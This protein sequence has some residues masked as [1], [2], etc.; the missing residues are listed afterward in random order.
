MTGATAP[1]PV[2]RGTARCWT[3][4]RQQACQ[5]V[6]EK[7][8][9]RIFAEEARALLTGAPFAHRAEGPIEAVL[10]DLSS[11][12]PLLAADIRQLATR[13]AELMHVQDIRL[14]LEA[15]TTNAC[16]KIHSDYTDLRLI[17]TYSGSGPEY[18][19]AG[20]EPAEASLKA[21]ATGDIALFKGRLFAVGHEPC[22]HRSPR[23]EG[24]GSSRLVLVIDTP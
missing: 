14:R 1:L 22:F 13:F 23:I 11:L 3:A 6:V 20:A 19:P 5:I 7:R 24:S 18:V 12:P 16:H 21:L 17:T 2:G 10:V 4:I 8:D 15:I 9:A